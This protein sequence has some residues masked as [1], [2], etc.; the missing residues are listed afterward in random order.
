MTSQL[1]LDQGGTYRQTEKVY[2]GPS[3]GW[4]HVPYETILNVVT[5]GTTTVLL[6]T[7]LVLVN[8]AGSV[9]IQLPSAKASP[10]GAQALPYSFVGKPITV[11]DIGGH[12]T[13]TPITILPFGSETIAGLSTV[14]LASNYGS[15]TFLPNLTL[16][17]YTLTQQ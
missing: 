3:V 6:G 5:A 13:A 11:L 9:T 17:G 1:D 15:F 8:V 10:A 2:L 4:V 16:G 7:T 12:A 14:S